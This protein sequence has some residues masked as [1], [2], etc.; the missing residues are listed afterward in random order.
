MKKTEAQLYKDKYTSVSRWQALEIM[1]LGTLGVYHSV[2]N[3]CEIATV[4]FWDGSMINLVF[5]DVIRVE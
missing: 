4:R 3:D 5:T 1:K 2:H